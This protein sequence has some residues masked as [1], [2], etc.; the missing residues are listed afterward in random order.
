M[1]KVYIERVTPDCIV[2]SFP[3]LEQSYTCK[4]ESDI[5]PAISDFLDG[6]PY[7]LIEESHPGYPED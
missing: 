7:E 1:I 3:T 2:L 5:K 6:K 4:Y